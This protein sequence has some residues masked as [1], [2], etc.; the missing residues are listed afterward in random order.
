MWSCGFEGFLC[1]LFEILI[2]FESNA[3]WYCKK[4]SSLTKYTIKLLCHI[5]ICMKLMALNFFFSVNFH[6]AVRPAMAAT[7]TIQF[8]LITACQN[9][10]CSAA[11]TT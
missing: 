10:S 11:K 2:S 1:A 5:Q 9:I 3:K 7:F 4:R 6:R 8:R